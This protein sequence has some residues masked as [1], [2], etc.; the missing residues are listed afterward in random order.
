MSFILTKLVSFLEDL[1]LIL[2]TILLLNLGWNIVVVR[3]F[4]EFFR[5]LGKKSITFKSRHDLREIDPVAIVHAHCFLV[6]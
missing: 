3:D 5:H 4:L 2:D 6:N 1:I